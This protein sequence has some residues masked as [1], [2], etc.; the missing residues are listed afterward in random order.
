MK[1]FRKRTRA[2]KAAPDLQTGFTDDPLPS[3]ES[4]AE[5]T[6]EVI[7]EGIML[8]K[9]A[10]GMALKNRIIVASL[11]QNAS[12]DEERY[13]Q[14]ARDALEDFARESET[15]AERLAAQRVKA[16]RVRGQAVHQHDYRVRDTTNLATREMVYRTIA[17]R[18][19]DYQNDPDMLH[20]LVHKARDSAWREIGAEIARELD[21]LRQIESVADENYDSEREKRLAEF[22]NLDLGPLL[23]AKKGRGGS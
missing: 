5:T 3:S 13:S 17:A 10:V 15:S 2:P 8:S 12:Y 6:P 11:S 9:F 16:S 14:A 23:K 7:E 19:R 18:L 4:V 21:R 22:R 20:E 1:L